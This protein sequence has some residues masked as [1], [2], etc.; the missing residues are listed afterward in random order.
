MA[1]PNT[2]NILNFN[3][4]QNIDLRVPLVSCLGWR[5]EGR[6]ARRPAVFR[7]PP[8]GSVWWRRY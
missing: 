3:V 6:P 5:G 2:G 8:A 4:G 1:D 7:V